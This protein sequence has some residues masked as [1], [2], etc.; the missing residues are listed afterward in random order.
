M[1]YTQPQPAGGVASSAA[2]YARFLRKLLNN[3]LRMGGL[4]GFHPVC[5]NPDTCPSDQAERTPV[6]DELYVPAVY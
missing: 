3:Q 2:D 5:T 1:F 4:L 6:P